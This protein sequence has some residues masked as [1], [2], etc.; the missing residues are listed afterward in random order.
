M[1]TSVLAETGIIVPDWGSIPVC[2]SRRDCLW[3]SRIGISWNPWVLQSTKDGSKCWSPEFL[4]KMKGLGPAVFPD[5]VQW[6]N[7]PE[8]LKLI[9]C[10][11]FL[12]KRST[13][14]PPYSEIYSAKNAWSKPVDPFITLRIIVNR[15]SGFSVSIIGHC[16][17]SL[18]IMIDEFYFSL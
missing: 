5:V 9:S 11:H 8:I 13:Q 18:F 10:R 12:I 17:N 14:V 15:F 7:C 3:L 2:S 4:Q 1:Q 16:F 6:S